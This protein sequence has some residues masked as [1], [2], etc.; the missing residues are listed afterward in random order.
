LTKRT[1]CSPEKPEGEIAVSTS[2]GLQSDWNYRIT[3]SREVAIKAKNDAVRKVSVIDVLTNLPFPLEAPAD[4]ALE[5]LEIEKAYFATFKVYTLKRV[6]DVSGDFVE[7]F[8]AVDVDQS[9]E[10]FIKAYWLYPNY[11]KFELTETESL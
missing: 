3:A 2:P 4:F 6:E 9:V 11:I 1:W 5:N 8:T 7:F 10:D